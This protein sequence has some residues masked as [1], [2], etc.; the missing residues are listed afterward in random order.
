MIFGA[1]DTP[2]GGILGSAWPRSTPARVFSRASTQ[3]PGSLHEQMKI[4]DNLLLF[5]DC[6]SCLLCM[7]RTNRLSR[8]R[9]PPA[10]T[11]GW[12]STWKLVDHIVTETKR[13]SLVQNAKGT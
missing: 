12:D 4:P 8:P 11:T 6:K 5:R 9:K 2:Y 13:R 10:S 7:P 1:E 3:S